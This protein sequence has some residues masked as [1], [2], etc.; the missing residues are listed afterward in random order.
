MDTD[1]LTKQFSAFVDEVVNTPMR[2]AE[3]LEIDPDAAASALG[4]RL[5]R[6]ME[7]QDAHIER[8]VTR[9]EIDDVA[10]A[11]YL[12]AALADEILLT[13][14]W[15]GRESWTRHLLESAVF[16]THVAGEAVFERIDRLLA[17]QDPSRR[18]LARLYLFALAMGFEGRYRDDAELGRLER[19]RLEL[20]QFVYQRRP[21]RS[22]HERVLDEA[23][24]KQTLSHLA[25]RGNA[26]IS[27]WLVLVILAALGLL[28]I[29]EILWLSTTWPI[30]DGLRDGLHGSGEQVVIR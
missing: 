27:R 11:R 24:Y 30:R 2:L 14:S 16:Q 9:F 1:L 4:V 26:A 19:Y 22:G 23:P 13:R 12:K 5:Q 7:F 3:S 29:S 20:F 21:D 10:D 6:L 18:R 17:E 25:P 15:A 28:V 8:E